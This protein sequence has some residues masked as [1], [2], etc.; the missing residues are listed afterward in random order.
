GVWVIV[1]PI[2]IPAT[3]AVVFPP[4]FFSSVVVMPRAVVV[5]CV[6]VVSIAPVVVIARLAMM[7]GARL[8]GV[9]VLVLVAIPVF[10]AIRRRVQSPR[11]Q[12]QRQSGSQFS[13][14]HCP[15]S[16]GAAEQCLG[17]T[18]ILPGAAPD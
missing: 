13:A 18:E 9:A 8:G 15:I 5:V 4:A 1:I 12:Y 7:V 17:G 16:C 10:I 3:A 2:A 14:E 6:S 11:R